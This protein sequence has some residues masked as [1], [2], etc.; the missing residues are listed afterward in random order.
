MNNSNKDM[1]NP[2]V[3]PDLIEMERFLLVS[4]KYIAVPK[5]IP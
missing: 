5:S 4:K 1:K 2:K 3:I